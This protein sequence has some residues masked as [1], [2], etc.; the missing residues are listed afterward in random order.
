MQAVAGEAGERLGHERR[1]HAGLVGQRVDHVAEED[2]PVGGGQRV[3]EEEVLLELPVGV[4]VVVGVVRPTEPVHVPRDGG[5]VIEHAGEALGVVAGQVLPVE[6]V[7]H[8]DAAVEPAPDQV[9]LRFD[10][11]HELHAPLVAQALQRVPQHDPRGVGPRL[12]LDLDVAHQH[13]DAVPPRE[14]HVARRIR[15]GDHVGIGRAL[16]HGPDGEAGEACSTDD[17]VHRRRRHELGAGTAVH[18]H[19][20]REEELDAVLSGPSL[21]HLAGVSHR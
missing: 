12:A 18:V 5:E 1:R 8:L 14:L 2:D 21:E 9:V 11:D 3:V 7:G 16:T 15:R 13:R 19:E 17:H 10:P 20:H 6:R 4:L